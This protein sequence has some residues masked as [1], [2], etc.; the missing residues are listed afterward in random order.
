MLAYS[1]KILKKKW[2]PLS[3]Q[4]SVPHFF[5]STSGSLAL[6]GLSLKIGN[7]DPD[8]QPTL[9]EEVPPPFAFICFPFLF[10]FNFS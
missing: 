8:D 4:P 9:K 1:E 2:R 5:K 7:E 3:R 6:P 10:F